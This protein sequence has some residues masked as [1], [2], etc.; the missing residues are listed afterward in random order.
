MFFKKPIEDDKGSEGD[1]REPHSTQFIL[2]V[3]EFFGGEGDMCVLDVVETGWDIL[4]FNSFG[5]IGC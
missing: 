3:A 5:F 1:G 2:P 4:D